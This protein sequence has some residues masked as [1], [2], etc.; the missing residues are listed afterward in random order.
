MSS[1]IGQRDQAPS[2]QR[3]LRR[4]GDQRLTAAELEPA[5]ELDWPAVTDAFR[6]G[7]A[8]AAEVVAAYVLP[9]VARLVRQLN[10]WSSD[11]DDLVQDILVTALARR[12][13][14]RGDARLETW[15]TRIAINACRAHGR[16]QWLRRRLFAG[17]IAGR[18]PPEAPSADD[19]ASKDEQAHRV[20]H[21]IA[22]LPTRYREAVVLCYLQGHAP[23]DAAESLGITRNA[24]DQRLKRARTQLQATLAIAAPDS[25]A[26][27]PQGASPRSEAP[28]NVPHQ[29]GR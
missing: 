28:T 19:L 26:H 13:T 14:F 17:W 24:L 15:L 25:C 29:P 10:A 8:A 1:L 23:A 22:Q 3:S 11:H 5:E 2:P 6:A 18:T 4:P 9:Y 20:R 21:A 12:H 7:D 16:R 27:Q